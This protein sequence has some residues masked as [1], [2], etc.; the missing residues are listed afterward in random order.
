MTE[1]PQTRLTGAEDIIW[2]LSVFYDGL[3]DARIEA[4][5]NALDQSADA[6]ATQYYG[7]VHE[8]S[9]SELH[10]AVA[11]LEQLSDQLYRVFSFAH[12]SY[13]T[14]SNNAEYGAFLQRVTEY[15]ASFSQK[16]LFFSLEW[17]AVPD[18]HVT[19][20]LDDPAVGQYRHYLEAER[21]FKPH[22]LTEAEEKI[23]VESSVNGRSAWVR[24]FT[25]LTG[26]L[27][28][29]VDGEEKLFTLALADIKSPDRELRRKTAA[30]ITE[31]LRAKRMELTFIFNVLAADKASTDRLRHYS[32]WVS[33]RN[34]DNKAPDAVVE[35]L[36]ETV[37]RN[38]DLVARHYHLKRVLLGYDELFDYDRYAPL[39]L[40]DGADHAFYTWEQARQ[41]VVGAFG[42]F[43]PQMA[44]VAD[45][46]FTE[47][48]IHAPIVAGK[49]G[50]AFSASCTPS[51][52]PFVLVNFSGKTSDIS[53]L[54]HELGH[55]VHQYLANSAQGLYGADTP[56]TT[57]EMASVFGE[58]LVFQDLIQREPNRHTQLA[59]LFE[60]VEDTFATVFRQTSMNRFEHALHNA[61]REEG[62]L[63]TERINALWM[64]TQQAMFGESVT[65]GENY[66]QWW[67]YIPH[68]LHTPGYVY[69]YA[70][71]E[72]LV[73]ALFN[74]YRE[75][76]ADFVPQYLEVVSSGG[77]D[78][79]DRILSKVGVDLNDPTFWQKGMDAV[80]ALI[81]QEEAL[82]KELYPD[83]FP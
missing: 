57:A 30:A 27:T 9:A 78:Y 77:N 17:Q 23:L 4:D 13:A 33:S 24:F 56:L 79:P 73:L 3:S 46:F 26:S 71:G 63:S 32:S 75:R 60:K 15:G 65:M 66:A 61:R 28:C 20:L 31:T 12:L 42:A 50:G 40:E 62:E 14:D 10:Q 47:R 39:T 74:L 19:A 11:T 16:L 2:D 37:T 8:L 6:F 67:S 69:A 68:F 34:L 51:S 59:M 1:A 25:Q 54:A 18:E 29:V 53:T 36:V 21:R 76:G 82:A 80:R 55:G 81:D 38:Y 45:R 52:H 22:T 70:F 44:E 49:R 58:M 35:A 5:L 83:K 43:S 7:R 64:Q 41:I 48:W 72:L